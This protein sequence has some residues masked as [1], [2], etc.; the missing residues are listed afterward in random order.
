MFETFA[1]RQIIVVL[2]QHNRLY[3]NGRDEG[4]EA[5]TERLHL[6]ASEN[7][8]ALMVKIVYKQPFT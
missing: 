1:F 5:C 6:S 3:K 7:V 8:C 2:H 4:R